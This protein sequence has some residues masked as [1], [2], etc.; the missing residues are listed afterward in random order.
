MDPSNLSPLLFQSNREESSSCSSWLGPVALASTK[1][2]HGR[3]LLATRDIQPGECLFVMNPTVSANI[4]TVKE[5][6]ITEGR[7]S[8]QNDS[9]NQTSRLES[10]AEQV[11]L[12][13]M[14]QSTQSASS[15]F[16]LLVDDQGERLLQDEIEKKD[17]LQVLLGISTRAVSSKDPAAVSDSVLQGIIRRN[18]FGPDFH[19]Y[20]T[21]EETW[22]THPDGEITF[23]YHR[24]LGLYPLAAIINH[25][26]SSNAVRVFCGE[27]MMVHAN[28]PIKQGQEIVWSY[29]SPIQP[30]HNRKAQLASK[31]G[32]DCLCERCRTEAEMY[33]NKMVDLHDRLRPLEPLNQSKVNSELPQ[34]QLSHCI[35]ELE[36][37][38][39]E[40]LLS[41]EARR[42]L[43]VAFL[44]LYIHFF[45]ATLRQ[46][47]NNNLVREQVLQLTT[48]LHF[49]LVAS[50]NAS[51]EHLS[52]LHLCYE[53]ASVLH[54]SDANKTKVRF[55]TEQ[56]KRA[57]MVRYGSLGND[58]ES[59][60]KV[61]K[62]SRGV[63]RQ[64]D[65]LLQASYNFI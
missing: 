13:E 12:E 29:I 44:H 50:H 3:G 59:V 9:I 8:T 26:C 7:M 4:Q 63:L 54:A 39:R 61:M 28:A 36:D 22:T 27:T 5:R 40:E 37:V 23:P 30:Y 62:H 49:S 34:S 21:M 19:N 60:R 11:L 56:L 1:V 20:N 14:K 51:T 6:W 10:I 15:S 64:R 38:L 42:F 52:I 41:N 65:G 43:R 45:N 55:W 46:Q 32:F 31:Y 25:S 48:Q 35:N 2:A 24:I 18:A 58:L 53:L 47:P 57:H 16:M 17:A 33:E